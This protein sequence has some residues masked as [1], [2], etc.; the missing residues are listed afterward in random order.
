M[1]QIAGGNL[2]YPVGSSA[3]SSVTTRRTRMQWGKEAQEGGEVCIL[4]ADSHLYRRNQHNI[5]KPVSSN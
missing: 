5:V 4:R 3:Q 1:K 2:L